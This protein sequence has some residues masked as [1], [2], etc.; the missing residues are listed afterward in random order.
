MENFLSKKECENLINTFNIL[1]HMKSEYGVNNTCILKVTPINILKKINKEFKFHNFL[2]TDNC[3]IARWPPGSLMNKH[4][5]PGDKI[6]FLLY[7]NDNFEGGETIVEN[8]VVKPKQGKILIFSNGI[9]YHEVKKIKKNNRF[10]LSAW[11]K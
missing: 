6:S 7:L 5:D 1:Q 9:M 4:I 2:K 11:Y 8:F 10:M 3:V